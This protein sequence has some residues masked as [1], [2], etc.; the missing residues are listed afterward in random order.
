MYNY[1]HLIKK[2]YVPSQGCAECFERQ[3]KHFTSYIICYMIKNSCDFARMMQYS[4]H[5]RRIV[6]EPYKKKR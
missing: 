3:E 6:K 1:A 4:G 2:K 5:V